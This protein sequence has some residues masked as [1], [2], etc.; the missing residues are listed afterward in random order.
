MMLVALMSLSLFAGEG[1]VAATDQ[2]MPAELLTLDTTPGAVELIIRDKMLTS[3]QVQLNAEAYNQGQVIYVVQ[4]GDT[5]AMIAARFGSSAS[6]IASAN[7]IL[8]PNLIYAG[9]RL[10]IPTGTIVPPA[11]RIIY[12][13]QRGDTLSGVA[14]RYRSTVS[15]LVRDNGIRNPNLIYVG[16]RVVVYPGS[17]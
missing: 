12:V 8:N 9:Q 1:T 17:Y 6:A 10:V 5:L 3:A 4:Y 7:K 16:Q 15:R 11:T 13:V 2:Q 14:F